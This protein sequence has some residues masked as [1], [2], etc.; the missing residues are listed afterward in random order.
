MPDLSLSDLPQSPTPD[1]NALATAALLSCRQAVLATQSA[2]IPGFPMTSVVPFGTAQDG[3]MICLLSDLAQHTRNL[4]LDTR[5][6]MLLH[7]DQQTNWQAAARLSVIGHLEP[8]DEEWHDLMETRSLYYQLHPELL[9]FD[10]RMDFRFWRLTPVRLRLIAGFGQIR[11]LDAV[12]PQFFHLTEAQRQPLQQA[13]PKGVQL[14]RACAYGLQL[15]EA[16]RVWFAAFREPVHGVE[17]LP[18][19][20]RDWQGSLRAPD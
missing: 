6:S 5:V 19:Q 8:L 15:L 1:Y 13:L 18:Q 7:D 17:A 16:G 4:N 9:D 3:S 14:V 10:R 2:S 11:W 12:Q 20:L